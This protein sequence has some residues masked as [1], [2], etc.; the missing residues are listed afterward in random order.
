M[1]ELDNRE[2]SE[3]DSHGTLDKYLKSMAR[4]EGEDVDNNK[5]KSKGCYYLGRTP[6]PRLT[7]LSIGIIDKR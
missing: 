3:G 5:I 2:R 6:W 7:S 4:Y 1:L